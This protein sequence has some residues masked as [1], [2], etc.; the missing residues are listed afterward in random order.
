MFRS[1]GCDAVKSACMTL[2]V[3]TSV[4]TRALRSMTSS[5]SSPRNPCAQ[6]EGERDVDRYAVGLRNTPES[7]APPC[8]V[9]TY[10]GWCEIA[11][12]D[13]KVAAAT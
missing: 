6:P 1:I 13:L 8:S 5:S 9:N 12:C 7:L 2:L 3:T 4:A 11:T 10:G